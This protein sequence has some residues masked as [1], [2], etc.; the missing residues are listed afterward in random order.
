MLYLL[1]ENILDIASGHFDLLISNQRKF[2]FEQG[3]PSST[4][5]ASMLTR[6]ILLNFIR[7]D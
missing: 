7:N 1:N 3:H 4:S 5:H 2:E 6:S